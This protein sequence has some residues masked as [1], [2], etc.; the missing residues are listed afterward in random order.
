MLFSSFSLGFSI[1]PFHVIMTYSSSVLPLIYR[2]TEQAIAL[3]QFCSTRLFKGQAA[4]TKRVVVRRIPGVISQTTS[5]FS[6]NQVILF[7]PLV[8]K[9]N[10]SRLKTKRMV[11]GCF[12][13]G[14]FEGSKPYESLS[15][16]RPSQDRRKQEINMIMT[17]GDTMEAP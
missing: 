12:V 17:K 2:P 5:A 9:T 10:D 6:N 15:M 7:H 16:T 14:C 13:R 1:F 11:L 8:L 4:F 3:Q